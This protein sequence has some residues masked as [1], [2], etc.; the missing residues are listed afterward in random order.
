MVAL[1]KFPL[2]WILPCLTTWSGVPVCS[3]LSVVSCVAS[4]VEVVLHVSPLLPFSFL[5]SSP[6]KS[7]RMQ[8]PP[9]QFRVG[10]LL[11]LQFGILA[12]DVVRS[13]APAGV[14]NVS[15]ATIDDAFALRNSEQ[16]RRVTGKDLLGRDFSVDA[17]PATLRW[18]PQ[19]I[20]V[21]LPCAEEQEY[22]LKTVRSIYEATPANVLAEII[23]VDD[24]S[25]PPL[26]ETV[27]TPEVQQRFRT[28]VIRHPTTVGLIGAK[29]TGGDMATGDIIVFFDCHVAPQFRWHVAF[30][31]LIGENRR[32]LV[33]PQITAL[34]IDTWSQVG[35]GG[36]MAKCYLTWD[37]D[38][39]W[40]N[41]DDMYAAVISGGLLG[42]S[43][44]W[45]AETGGYDEQMLGWGGENLDQSLRVWLCGGE[46]V[47]AS[48]SFVA[49]MWRTGDPRTAVRYQRVGDT[50]VN[51]ARAVYAWYDEFAEK[52][53]HYPSFSSRV[54]RDVPGD[55]PWYGNVSNILAVKDRLGC[56]PFAWFLR[57]FKTLYEDAGMIPREIFMMRSSSGLCLRYLGQA[58][59]SQSGFGSARL[60]S[61][62][63]QSDDRLF[64][65][66]ANI[67]QS[68]NRRC[69]SGLRAWN[70][71]QC[72]QSIEA[73]GSFRTAVCDVS[74]GRREQRW[75]LSTLGHLESGWRCASAAGMELQSNCLDGN[76]WEMHAVKET[77]EAKLYARARSEQ[78]ELFRVLDK[79]LADSGVQR[80]DFLCLL[81][82]IFCC[83]MH[84]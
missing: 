9:F 47:T 64:W 39:K 13:S 83:Y 59:T 5:R 68:A 27:L 41:S 22:A 81:V 31:R 76:V 4:V 56:R 52:L 44:W 72:L 6:D 66:L 84:F 71:D 57:R 32:R 24:G 80:C 74:G 53:M 78:P 38:F 14:D 73:D 10:I 40:F 45:W 55:L 60:A 7:R 62:E 2:L 48:D 21:V 16:M 3:F 11:V 75:S 34:N 15:E 65:H 70:T 30:L 33:V 19:T 69:C 8:V 77:L 17:D 43:R 82:L 36:G 20:S 61:C 42:M 63:P 35:R 46:I 26:A 54:Q 50:S 18:A 12:I 25:R 1:W 49:H 37:A 67:D 51:R 28:R 23:V 79:Q 29:K 58:G